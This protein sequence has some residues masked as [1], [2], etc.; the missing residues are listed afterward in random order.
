MCGVLA[1]GIVVEGAPMLKWVDSL[2]KTHLK[3]SSSEF[4]TSPIGISLICY[5]I[6]TEVLHNREM[7]IGT[8]RKHRRKSCR[9]GKGWTFKGKVSEKIIS[10]IFWEEVIF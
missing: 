7:K 3:A 4:K 10:K 1:W 2:P 8:V 9:A 5:G 6:A